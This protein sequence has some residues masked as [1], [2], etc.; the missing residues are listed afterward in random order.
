MQRIFP[1]EPTNFG[2]QTE[3]DERYQW[4]VKSAAIISILLAMTILNQTNVMVSKKARTA[5]ALNVDLPKVEPG[6]QLPLQP[7]AEPAPSIILESAPAPRA[8][9]NPARIQSRPAA[10]RPFATAK[11]AA[12]SPPQSDP[13]LS[14]MMPDPTA[15]PAANMAMVPTAQ[16]LKVMPDVAK[17]ATITT[18]T[19]FTG[20]KG[21][22]AAKKVVKP[23]T[24]GSGTRI[25]VSV[26]SPRTVSPAS[27]PGQV[28]S[29]KAETKGKVAPV[30]IP[31]VAGTGAMG[32]NGK[33]GN[34]TIPRS[35]P[36]TV[37]PKLPVAPAN[38]VGLISKAP[39]QLGSD[40]P[41]N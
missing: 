10:A 39:I 27:I 2:V 6:L 31:A 32:S 17:S 22:K 18:S 30:S 21:P 38:K 37:T 16:S 20:V 5:V 15:Q 25:G 3:A 9:A 40:G 33:V 29:M 23:A 13:G 1:P 8:D 7:T 28:G 14:L 34:V 36:L 35:T 11:P 24:I 19:S 41:Q 12:P 4:I 26:G